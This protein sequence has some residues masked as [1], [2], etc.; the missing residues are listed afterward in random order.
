M[1]Q[2]LYYTHD[3]QNN[4]F[5]FNPESNNTWD[6]QNLLLA[7]KDDIDRQGKGSIVDCDGFL[8]YAYGRTF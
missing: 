8:V 1:T 7:Y 2:Y 4:I 3:S 5:G 6:G